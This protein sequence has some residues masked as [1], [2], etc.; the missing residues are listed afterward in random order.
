MTRS[1][2][3]ELFTPY[4][5]PEREFRSLRRHFKTLILD[6]LRSPDSNLFSDQEYSEEEVAKTMAKTI[7]Q[8]ISKTRADYRSGVARPRI[9]DKDNFELKGQFLK[10][11]HTNNFSGREIK[12]VNENV[13]AA[14]VGCE[15]CKRPNYTKD[16]PL[17]EEWKT[18]EEAY[19]M[20]FDR[21]FQ[22]GGYKAAASGFYQMNN[23][24]PSYHERRQSMVDTLSKFMSKSAK[25]H[26]ENSNLI[27]EIRALT[28]VAIRNQGASIKTLEIQIGQMSKI[29]L[30]VGKGR[31]IFTSVKPASSLIKRVY[32]LSLRERIELD[33]EARLIRE[34]LVL[35]RSLDPF[36]EDYIVLNDLKEPFE[37]RINQGDDL[38]PTIKEVLENMDLYRDEGMGDVI[39]SEPFLREVGIKTRRFEGMINIYNG[40]DEKMELKR[41]TRSS[42]ATTTITTI[43]VTDAQ[44]KAL[45][46][47]GIADALAARDANRSRNNKDSHD[48][49]T[50]VRRQALLPHDNC[51]VEKIKFGTCTL[52]GSSLTW[53]NSHV[54]IVGHDVAY[55]MTW[56]NLKNKMIDKYCPRGEI[57]KPEELALMYARMFLEESDRIE[58]YV[59]GL[60]D[61]IYRNKMASKIKTMQDEVE[62][63][64][65]LMDKKIRTFAKREK[66]PYRGSKP[67]C[68]KC[69][70]HHDGPC[71]PKCHKCNRVGHLDRDC[72]SLTNANT[73]NNQR[74]TEA[75]QKATCFECKAHGHFKRKCPKLRITTVVIKVEM[76]MHQ[77][78][79]MCTGLH[80]LA[81][82]EMKEL[83]DQLKELSDKGFIRLSSS[84]WGALF[85]IQQYLQNKHYALWEVIE[86]GDSY[87]TPPEET[88]KGLANESSSRKK[89]RTVAI[90][91]ED[92]QKRRNDVKARTTLLLALPDEHQD[93][94]D[95]MSLDDVY[96]HLKVYK[97]EVQKKSASNS[98]NMTFISSS[99]TSSGKGKVHTASVPTASIQV[100]T[101]STD[102]VAASLSHDTICA[103]IATQSN[104]SQIKYEDI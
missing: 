83:S 81:P 49:R 25:R 74:G 88:C 20:Q 85:R 3:S 7:E 17:K 77:Q 35:N 91:I 69:N 82:F 9:K 79:C 76:A 53:W 19:Y 30:R 27:K 44:L 26:H 96:N 28:D 39:F 58:M 37:L 40:N 75:G 57:K 18:H 89:G 51:T 98:Q 92:M 101:A 29:T 61:M 87:K 56:T 86:F 67:M 12:K 45:I 84:P 63:A 54:K 90:T 73:A 21:P 16:W 36:F 48:S 24:N 42:P 64:T 10:E 68:F 50:G 94:L 1:S 8:Y 22:R 99:N 60:P 33:L 78:K 100:S 80:R 41:T 104:G 13:Y 55:S 38:M 71:A 43:P 65:E 93:D 97:P 5:E 102:I 103:Y 47:Q 14:Q 70:Y 46:D 52:L 31:I 66:K 32:M 72:R 95:T 62:F 23:A 2:T 6:K 34:T 11:L 4:K 15:Q 59:S